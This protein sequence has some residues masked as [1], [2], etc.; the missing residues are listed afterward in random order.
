MTVKPAQPRTH[1]PGRRGSLARTLQIAFLLLALGP[2]FCVSTLMLWRQYQSSQQQVI[3]QLTSVATLKAAEVETWFNSLP[4][5]LELL[6]GNP[7]VNANIITLIA[8]EHNEIILAGWRQVLADTLLV[9]QASGHKFEE[10]FLIDAAGRVIVSTDPQREAS[11][12]SDQVFFKEGLKAPY[13]QPP[14]PSAL[15]G[16]QSIIFAATPVK[17]A[18]GMVRGVLVGAASL[19]TPGTIMSERSGLGDTGETYLVGPDS[20]LLTAPRP[21][22]AEAVPRVNTWGAIQ[23]LQGKNGSGVYLNYQDPPLQVLGVYR[24]LPGMQAALLA[25]Q[26]QEEALANILQNIWLSLALTLLTILATVAATVVVVRSI[27]TPLESLTSAATRLAGGD[28]N[29]DAESA[30]AAGQALSTVIKRDDEI[31][32]L[33]EAFNTMTIQLRELIETLEERVSQRTRELSTVNDVTAVVSRSL[34]LDV[35]LPEVLDKTIEVMGMDAGVIREMD[36]GQASLCLA[37]HQGVSQRFVRQMDVIPME[38]ATIARAVVETCTPQVLLVSGYPEG[39]IRK[40]LEQEGICLV[41]SIPL[42]A[43]DKVE[44]V[45]NL[46]SYSA[47]PP[48]PDILAVASAIGQQ[49]GVA[50][51]NARLYRQMVDYAQR[52]ED[53]RRSADAASLAKSRFLANMSHELR[54][55]LNAILGFTRMVRRKG[56]DSLPEKQLENLDKVLISADH[57]LGLINSVL[58]LSKI[59][60][61]QVEAQPKHFSIDD[62]I[63]VAL[64]TAQPLLRPGVGLVADLQT[65]SEAIYTDPDKLRQILLNLL[66]NAAKFTHKGQVTL[67]ARRHDNLLRVDVADTGTGISEEAQERIFDEFQQADLNTARQYGGTGLG[68]TISRKLARILGG[69]LTLTSQLGAGSTFTLT[70]LWNCAEP[71]SA[72]TAAQPGL[73]TD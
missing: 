29:Q 6:V 57:L 45:I 68:L 41:L 22:P 27:A 25:E 70:V 59:E 31:G 48:S 16:N 51:E 9:A 18:A 30:T 63:Q 72:Q 65:G 14:A 56:Q 26:N 19:D 11:N 58:D 53:A 44:G 28:L 3:A 13:V 33:A 34:D 67:T 15:Y 20:T 12:L 64:N 38:D 52:M 24:W 62:L 66:S 71:P 21:V 35:I 4:L 36:P 32:T 60:A 42:M 17:D 50:M 1:T 49:V 55:P 47:N 2:L 37:A 61:G 46:F 40:M 43:Q 5:D 73:Q 54:T 7:S 10:V 39:D 23:A 69:D 8:S